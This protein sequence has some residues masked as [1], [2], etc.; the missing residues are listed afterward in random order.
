MGDAEHVGGAL[1]DK[2]EASKFSM[3]I[4][5]VELCGF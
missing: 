5:L 2:Y 4:N 3:G 1:Q